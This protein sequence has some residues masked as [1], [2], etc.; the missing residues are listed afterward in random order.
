MIQVLVP[1]IG[2]QMT[3]YLDYHIKEKKHAL[4]AKKE[5]LRNRGIVYKEDENDLQELPRFEFNEKVPNCRIK[6]YFNIFLIVDFISHSCYMSFLT[7]RSFVLWLCQVLNL[8]VTIKRSFA[9]QELF[10][11]CE[12]VV[13]RPFDEVLIQATVDASDVQHQRIV[14]KL[15]RPVIEGYSVPSIRSEDEA[16]K[17]K[18]K[19]IAKVQKTQQQGKADT[20]KKKQGQKAATEETAA[21]KAPKSKKAK[22]K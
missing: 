6:Y 20:K 4:K 5:E 14:T 9:L 13:L 11:Q 22:N 19:P 16:S 3:L 8:R 21:A 10:V 18:L 17:S 15:V 12:D 1:A 2:Q 7:Q